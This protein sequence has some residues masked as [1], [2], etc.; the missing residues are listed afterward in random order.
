MDLVS[1]VGTC[2]GVNGGFA[3]KTQTKS[4]VGIA[5]YVGDNTEM[6]SDF[7]PG[8]HVVEATREYGSNSFIEN[9]AVGQTESAQTSG[10]FSPSGL[11]PLASEVP[12]GRRKF[13]VAARLS[14]GTNQQCE[15]V[16]GFGERLKL[17]H[18]HDDTDGRAITIA[19]GLTD[20]T[21]QRLA[22]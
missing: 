10:C 9:I 4:F 14:Q 21:R 5:T 3:S 2:I 13:L 8:E 17:V 22:G 11:G 19:N 12:T 16:E 18:A 6:E 20:Q 15:S 7:A 1:V